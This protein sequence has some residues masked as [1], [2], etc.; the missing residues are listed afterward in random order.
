MSPNLAFSPAGPQIKFFPLLYAP[1]F[2]SRGHLAPYFESLLYKLASGT[3][4]QQPKKIKL[5][6]SRGS[7]I[8]AIF[9]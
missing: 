4:I 7:D 5:S 3:W 2:R 6:D 8:S 9:G 1:E